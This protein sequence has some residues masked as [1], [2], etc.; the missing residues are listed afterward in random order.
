[1]LAKCQG[2][3]HVVN[4][5][6]YASAPVAILMEKCERS[7]EGVLGASFSFSFRMR[8]CLEIATGLDFLHKRGI[9]HLDV[10]DGNVM[11]GSD[12]RF[13][14]VDFGEAVVDTGDLQLRRG[15]AGFMAPEVCFVSEA[16][17]FSGRRADIFSFAMTAFVIVNHGKAALEDE[18]FLP[19]RALFREFQTSEIWTAAMKEKVRPSAPVPQWLRS[20]WVQDP[21][22]RNDLGFIIQT[23]KEI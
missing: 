7:L 12:E 6:G 21:K 5:I 17:G 10:K 14:L 20:I 19:F 23:L 15:T 22:Q 3:P 16:E 4:L 13:K 2:S 18:M 11:V 1:M 9:A 8:M